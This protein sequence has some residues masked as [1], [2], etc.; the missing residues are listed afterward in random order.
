M[1]LHDHHYA[2]G[3]DDLDRALMT[4]LMDDGRATWADLAEALG[5]SAPAVA[6]RV[7]R[8][9]ERGVIR[10]YAALASAAM[11]APVCAFVAV[12]LRPGG[13]PAA[14]LRAVDAMEPALECHRLAARDD[15]LL[16]LRCRSLA[17]L[18]RLVDQELARI[19]G[20]ESVKPSIA[21]ASPKETARL[22]LSRAA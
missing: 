9:E 4:R 1:E 20:V 18:R 7:R 13:D 12:N 3:L 10:G 2:N 17:D 6:A 21:I 11:F 16:K 15:Y 22:P 5:I 14:F 8:L 19:E